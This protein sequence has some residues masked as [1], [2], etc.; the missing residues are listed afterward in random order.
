MPIYWNGVL[1]CRLCCKAI[2]H[3]HGL[4]SYTGAELAPLMSDDAITM[5][6]LLPRPIKIY[7][8]QYIKT[9]PNAILEIDYIAYSFPISARVSI[10]PSILGLTN[11]YGSR[12]PYSLYLFF[13]NKIRAISFCYYG[14]IVRL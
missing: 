5:R 10:E 13:R 8:G 4:T 9:S 3:W 11:T 6:I 12:R 1:M 14:Y 7:V 2:G